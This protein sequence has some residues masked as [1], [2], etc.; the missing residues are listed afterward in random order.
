MALQR[1]WTGAFGGDE[2][3]HMRPDVATG[4]R[5]PDVVLPA[6]VR[7]AP[8]LMAPGLLMIGLSVAL[9]VGAGVLMPLVEQGVAGLFDPT[10]YVKAVLP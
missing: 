4:G 6:E 10:D 9:F 8:R 7:V 3:T 1:L 5:G 2:L